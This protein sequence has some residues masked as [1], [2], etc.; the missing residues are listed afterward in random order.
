MPYL[1]SFLYYG[2]VLYRRIYCIKRCVNV[3]DTT[4]KAPASVTTAADNPFSTTVDSRYL[5]QPLISK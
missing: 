2:I 5:E 1:F 3:V 4:L